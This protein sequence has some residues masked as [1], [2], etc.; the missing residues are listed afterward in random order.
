MLYTGAVEPRTV[1]QLTEDQLLGGEQTLFAEGLDGAIVGVVRGGPG[2]PRVAYSLRKALS[3][4][5]GEEMSEDEAVE[6][7]LQRALQASVPY[8]PVFVDDSYL[9]ENNSNGKTD[10]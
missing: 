10:L 9:E 2:D 5:R 4:V 3:L 1:R 8:A 6:W 7:L